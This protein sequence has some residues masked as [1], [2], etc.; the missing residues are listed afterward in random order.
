[1]GLEYVKL[2]QLY[3]T[4]CKVKKIF[5]FQEKPGVIIEMQTMKPMLVEEIESP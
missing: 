4:S 1:M 3:L 2:L 5:N